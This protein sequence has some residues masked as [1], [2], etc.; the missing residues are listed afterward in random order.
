M[1]VTLVESWDDLPG[2]AAPGLTLVTAAA[3]DAPGAVLS[4]AEATSE[5]ARRWKRADAR[6]HV[7]LTAERLAV[8]EAELAERRLGLPDGA[9]GA[10]PDVVRRLADAA[11]SSVT[12]AARLAAEVEEL[13]PA[14]PVDPGA[15]R[16]VLDADT[17]VAHVRGEL[18]LVSRRAVRVLLGANITGVA[19]VA[20]RLVTGVVEPVFPLVGLLPVASLSYALIGTALARRRVSR[21]STSLSTSLQLAG[22]RTVSGLSA[23]RARLESH[24]R[25]ADAAAS[26]GRAADRA[27]RRLAQAAGVG[28]E[29]AEVA[30]LV[31]RL[32][33]LR[34]AQEAW[35]TARAAHDE[36]SALADGPASDEPLLVAA[37]CDEEL[38]DRLLQ[39]SGRCPVVV[40]SP[41]PA[42]RRWVEAH[43]AVAAPA[44]RR[45]RSVPTDDAAEEA[46][47]PATMPHVD[48][49]PGDAGPIDLR[50][51]VLSSLRRAMALRS[52]GRNSDEPRRQAQ[53]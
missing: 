6:R 19:I 3:D 43:G 15:E 51:R 52:S 20:G 30:D 29:P 46:T 23:R 47:G 44:R 21:A 11:A 27:L 7:E 48:A 24:T 13:G 28:V 12:K 49:T 16:A 34:A 53:A 2:E 37:G 10:D 18:D 26:A 38:L 17:Y 45:L 4:P 9:H 40:V 50:E 39:A 5:L 36:A 32:V 33:A 1:A 42:V 14:P 22:V 25:R 31:E 35:R 8:A 41:D